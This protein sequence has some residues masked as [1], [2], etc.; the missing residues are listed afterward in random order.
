MRYLDFLFQLLRQTPLH[1]RVEFSVGRNEP[2][3]GRLVPVSS[4]IKCKINRSM[5]AGPQAQ[6]G[7]CFCDLLNTRR[8]RHNSRAW[9]KEVAELKRLKCAPEH[10]PR[11]IRSCLFLPGTRMCWARYSTDC[12]ISP[13]NNRRIFRMRNGSWFVF[14]PCQFNCIKYR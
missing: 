6:N 5:S 2:R 14:A 3:G 7:C 12:F 10:A 13:P 11:W 8:Y 4:H 9:G 1:R